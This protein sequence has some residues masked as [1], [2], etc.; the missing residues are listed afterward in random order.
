MTWKK[1]ADVFLQLIFK[2][3][4]MCQKVRAEGPDRRKIFKKLMKINLE[5][6][7][8]NDI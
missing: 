1:K 5:V 4:V 3:T 8:S 6:N 7:L 2:L